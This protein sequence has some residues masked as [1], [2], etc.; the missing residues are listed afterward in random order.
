MEVLVER[1]RTSN[2]VV[3]EISLHLD[4]CSWHNRHIYTNH[5]HGFHGAIGIATGKL[6]DFTGTCTV[7]RDGN[8]EVAVGNGK[9]I[10]LGITESV[11]NSC[12][13]YDNR[14][15]GIHTGECE[16]KCGLLLGTSNKKCSKSCKEKSTFHC[17]GVR[18]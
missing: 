3:A 17:I 13:V 12:I 4:F 11:G 1:N 15:L 14:I 10:D 5:A 7:A 8:R 18:S 16:G 6:V 9:G 2:G